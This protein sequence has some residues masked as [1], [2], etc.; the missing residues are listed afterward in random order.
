MGFFRD[1]FPELGFKQISVGKPLLD[2]PKKGEGPAFA[3]VK[4]VAAFPGTALDA[5]WRLV[6]EGQVKASDTN[7]SVALDLGVAAFENPYGLPIEWHSNVINNGVQP[8][9][10]VFLIMQAASAAIKGYT[11]ESQ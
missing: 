8:G 1:L 11:G 4:R 7:E 5:Y 10:E 2:F 3:D 6:V 9:S